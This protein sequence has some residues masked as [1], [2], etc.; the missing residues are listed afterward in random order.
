MTVQTAESSYGHHHPDKQKGG[1]EAIGPADA[2]TSL[3]CAPRKCAARGRDQM[4]RAGEHS[5]MNLDE[6]TIALTLHLFG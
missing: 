2:L 4:A 3:I 6:L 5:P 1:V